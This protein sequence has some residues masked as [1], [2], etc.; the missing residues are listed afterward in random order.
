MATLPDFP[1]R[2]LIPTL[3][4]AYIIFMPYSGKAWTVGFA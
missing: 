3:Y 1:Y 2:I 4:L